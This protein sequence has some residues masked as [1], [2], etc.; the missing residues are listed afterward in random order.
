[1]DESFI[2]VSIFFC[3]THNNTATYYTI[4]SINHERLSRNP[5]R[6]QG[7]GTRTASFIK[8][9]DCAMGSKS[10][11]QAG[12]PSTTHELCFDMVNGFHLELFMLVVSL[13]TCLLELAR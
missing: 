1:M 11:A 7:R 13:S 4:A 2:R 3:V 10:H 8:A 9:K 6:R 5:G 12:R